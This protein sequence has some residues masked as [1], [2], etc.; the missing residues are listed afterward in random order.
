MLVKKQIDD[1]LKALE[2]IKQKKK[3]EEEKEEE[4]LEE[5]LFVKNQMRK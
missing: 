4:N 2:K 5:Q 3:E 1:M